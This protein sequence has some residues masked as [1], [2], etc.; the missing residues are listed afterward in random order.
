MGGRRAGGMGREA[1]RRS[2]AQL[3]L[4]YRVLLTLRFSYSASPLPPAFA[5][6]STPPS[7]HP[8]NHQ[9][10]PWHGRRHAGGPAAWVL[11]I[12]V[13]VL[14]FGF[15]KHPKPLPLGVAAGMRAGLLQ[16]DPAGTH[17]PILK[18]RWGAPKAWFWKGSWYF[19][20][21]TPSACPRGLL[22][23]GPPRVG[24]TWPPDLAA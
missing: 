1:G 9:V 3:V 7:T 5:A 17:L 18:A 19:N 15:H 21:K 6:L 12:W 23:W 16:P 22:A 8:P 4:H 2:A 10:R 13:G 11:G 20:P 24:L 14:G